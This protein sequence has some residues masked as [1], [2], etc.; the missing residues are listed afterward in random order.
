LLAPVDWVHEGERLGT[1]QIVLSGGLPHKDAYLT[2]G[3]FPDVIRPLLAFSL[4]GESIAADRL[5]GMLIEPL[6]Y[7]AAAY[8]L[9]HLFPEMWIRWV[10]IASFVLFP[11]L[12]VPRHILI[13][14]GLA[15]LAQWVRQRKRSR[16]VLAGLTPGLAYLGS[17]MEHASFIF[18]STF[19]FPVVWL[20][21]V[22]ATQW[23]G[24]SGEEGDE[25]IK[26]WCEQVLGPILIGLAMGFVPLVTYLL[27]SGTGGAFMADLLNRAVNDMVVK[28][29][30]YP[31]FSL[32]NFIWYGVPAT[33]GAAALLYAW[34]MLRGDQAWMAILPVLLFGL[35]SFI[36]AIH[37]CCPTYGKLATVIFPFVVLVVLILYLSVTESMTKGVGRAEGSSSHLSRGIL[38]ITALVGTFIVWQSST[39]EWSPKQ[40]I[41]R[42]LF[43][44]FGIVLMG[45]A[46]TG[47]MRRPFFEKHRRLCLVSFPIAALIV[48]VWLFANAKPQILAAQ[49]QKPRLIDHLA[50]LIPLYMNAGGAFSRET[51]AYIK[52]ETLNYVKEKA[53]TGQ[54]VVILAAGSGIYYFLANTTPP[55]RFAEVYHAMTD[56][57]ARE[58]ITSLRMSQADLLVACHDGGK[59]VTGWPMNP[60]LIS[61]VAEV[62]ADTG[63]RLRSQLL[64][65]D[66]SFSV[67]RHRDNLHAGNA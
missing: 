7:V 59:R 5:F 31:E 62:Y 65:E 48:S 56:S 52:D 26:T 63:V 64:G 35:A 66:C 17:T 42:I 1:A 9:W 28:R 61:Y 36:Y 60:H 19:A 18:A 44:F 50:R 47:I 12:L 10:G 32:A 29:D 51:P 14:V 2:H 53:R 24:S 27:V 33:Y 23:G 8:F 22:R 3:L 4:F 30:P 34:K 43:P 20:G 55:N 67:W 25:P 49:L 6:A 58:V 11:V 45:S 13:F 57:T 46:V 40:V 54:R 21:S 16:L 37:G 41:P 39:Q 38:T 15:F